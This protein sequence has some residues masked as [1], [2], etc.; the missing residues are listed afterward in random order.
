MNPHTKPPFPRANKEMIND[1]KNIIEKMKIK[2]NS[3]E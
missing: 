3:Y 1:I 2:L